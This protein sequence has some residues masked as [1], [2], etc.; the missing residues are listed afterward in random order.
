MKPR[1]SMSA[2]ARISV[3]GLHQLVAELS[4]WQGEFDFDRSNRR[5][6]AKALGWRPRIELRDGLRQ[7]DIYGSTFLFNQPR[8]DLVSWSVGS[9]S[10]NFPH[11]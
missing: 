7:I 8:Y 6:A 1:R 2:A 9:S 10:A 3:L 5:H 11:I 4:G